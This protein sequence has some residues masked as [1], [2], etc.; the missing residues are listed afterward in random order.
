[1]GN[2]AGVSRNAGNLP[3]NLPGSIWYGMYPKPTLVA[4]VEGKMAAKIVAHALKESSS[5]FLE[6]PHCGRRGD[7]VFFTPVPYASLGDDPLFTRPTG[8]FEPRAI[9]RDPIGAPEFTVPVLSPVC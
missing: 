9:A 2:R 3:Q 6:C 5:S 1:M 8:P 4:C 7:K